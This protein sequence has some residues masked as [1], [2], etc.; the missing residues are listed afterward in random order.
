MERKTE[1]KFRNGGKIPK[2]SKNTKSEWDEW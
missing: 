2:P 1:G